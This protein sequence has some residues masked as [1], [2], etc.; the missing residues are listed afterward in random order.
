MFKSTIEMG[1]TSKRSQS[2]SNDPVPGGFYKMDRHWGNGRKSQDFIILVRPSPYIS[3]N[4][5][6]H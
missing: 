3:I 4:F 6:V 2:Y 5:E 1:L